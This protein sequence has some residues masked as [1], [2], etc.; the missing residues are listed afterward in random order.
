MVVFEY[1]VFHQS[2][3][4]VI[5]FSLESLE[6]WTLNWLKGNQNHRD[7]SI[8]CINE[9]MSSKSTLLMTI[10]GV[11]GYIFDK[12]SYGFNTVSMKLC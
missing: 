6:S 3:W 2:V 4:L 12:P 9:E 5:L 8:N 1:H 10:A 11:N 7:E